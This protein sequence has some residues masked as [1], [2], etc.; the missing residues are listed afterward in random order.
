M[1]SDT[2]WHVLHAPLFHTQY[3]Q[4]I[5]NFYGV[6]FHFRGSAFGAA[7]EVLPRVLAISIKRYK[8]AASLEA[9]CPLYTYCVIR[10]AS[11]NS[12]GGGL[13]TR[14]L[15]NYLLIMCI[16][17]RLGYIWKD[18]LKPGF[19][20]WQFFFF[21]FFYFCLLRSKLD[22]NSLFSLLLPEARSFKQEQHIFATVALPRPSLLGMKLKKDHE[23]SHLRETLSMFCIFIITFREL[24]GGMG[25]KSLSYIM[26]L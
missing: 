6:L 10:T 23:A 18:M 12:C 4:H 17:S 15:Y 22:F 20:F 3:E 1:G 24:G 26:M 2:T 19:D 25:K 11:D 13:G 9:K 16:P 5:G 14:L 7:M 8:K 21:S